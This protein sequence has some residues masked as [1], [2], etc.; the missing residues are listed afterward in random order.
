MILLTATCTSWVQVI[1]LPSASQVAGVTD[2]HH[3]GWPIF[4]FSVE[5]G[6]YY[7]GQAGLEFLIPSDPPDLVSQRVGITGMSHCA[8]LFLFWRLGLALLLS[9]L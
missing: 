4:V 9:S 3:H 1:A 5:T 6:F 7:V 8:Q 2:A